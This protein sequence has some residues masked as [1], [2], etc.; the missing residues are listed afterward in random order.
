MSADPSATFSESAP[1][2]P[3]P[4]RAP[5][6]KAAKADTETSP[7]TKKVAAKKTAAKKTATAPVAESSPVE[8][9]T[10]TSRAKPK[11]AAASQPELPLSPPSEKAPRPKRSAAKRPTA[12]ASADTPPPA[13]ELASPPRQEQPQSAAPAQL[14]SAPPPSSDHPS[15]ENRSSGWEQ[16]DPRDRRDGRGDRGRRDRGPRGPRPDQGQR[17]DQSPRPDQTQRYDQSPR[18]DQ[19]QRYDQN[20][21]PN[22]GDS[23]QP[24]SD[25]PSGPESNRSR[26]W[27]ERRNRFKKW[28]DRRRGVDSSDGSGTAPFQSGDAQGSEAPPPMVPLG[29]P[30][31]AE[32]IL[33]L[34]SKGYGFLRQRSHAF[35]QLAQ[36]PFVDPD[37]IRKFGLREGM[38][39]KGQACKAQRGQQ[40]TEITEVNCRVPDAMREL[41]LFEDLK[42]VNPSKRIQLETDKNR[43]TTRVID[44]FTPVGRGQR[45]LIVA[46]PRTGKTTLLQHIAEAVSSNHPGMHL[47]LL[48]VDERPEEVTEFKR[49]LPNAEIFA[50]SNDQD[51]KSHTRIAQFAIERA[52]RLVECG[53]H[54]FILLDSITRL[55]RAFNN[56]KQGG[57]TMSGGVGV[58][59]LEIPRRLFAAARNTREAGSL[60]ILAT[61]LIETG[62]RMDDLIFQE[63]KGTGNMELVLDRKIAEQ[64]YYPAANILKSGTRREELLLQSFQLD[65]IHMLRR[66]LAGHKPIEALQRVISLLERYPSNAQMLVDLPSKS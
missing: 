7:A 39:V 29:P 15:H 66:G 19:G 3:K 26:R 55:A 23:R 44:M 52:K 18:P 17:Y 56:A 50:S 59:A 11:A 37:L 46:P 24:R 14:D 53:E 49:I 57:A 25:D 13:V 41:P 33:E 64:M 10:R 1:A 5:A 34:T 63:F 47:M 48:L 54:V 61:A 4:K 12:A 60:T 35:A 27:N 36:D 21:R 31:P 22:Q 32:G 30:E 38:L 16:R 43:L 45:G 20:P 8:K 6:K 40:M 62:S 28:K 2:T 58:G 51:I 65:K 9:P 42:A